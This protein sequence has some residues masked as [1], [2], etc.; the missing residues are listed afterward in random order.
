MNIDSIKETLIRKIPLTSQA[1]E[2]L[3]K[4]FDRAWLEIFSVLASLIFN[5]T[6][7]TLLAPTIILPIICGLCA[8]YNL[9][10]LLKGQSIRSRKVKALKITI[11]NW[12][13]NKYTP[14]L[15]NNLRSIYLPSLKQV[16]AFISIDVTISDNHET[17]P[18]KGFLFCDGIYISYKAV[19]ASLKCDFRVIREPMSSHEIGS[20]V[21][22]ISQTLPKIPKDIIEITQYSSTKHYKFSG[23]NSF[24]TAYH[25]QAISHKN[26]RAEKYDKKHT[27]S[28]SATFEDL[29]PSNINLPKGPKKVLSE[30]QQEA[31]LRLKLLLSD[32]YERRKQVEDF[33]MQIVIN[34]EELNGRQPL[35]VSDQ[36]IG[37]D[38][39]STLNGSIPKRIE[40]KG[41]GKSGDVILTD[42]EIKALLN[43]KE[44]YYLYIVDNCF[45]N[46]PKNLYILQNLEL[47][48]FKKTY[49]EHYF[50][51]SSLK[52]AAE[53]ICSL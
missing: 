31:G 24:P 47:H 34:F 1:K 4:E 12:F 27:I 38:I 29:S 36:N 45:G 8:F 7:A 33:A 32:I 49:A 2:Y 11:E 6:L 9:L 52:E 26:S 28:S 42:N 23:K 14:L 43:Y 40:V 46:L 30:L 53:L 16:K 19:S 35:D 51:Y 44:G 37:Y 21:D 48:N 39:I 13:D 18:Q 25:S 20:I 50:S 15:E 3:V 17:S 41:L 10:D 22:L 5:L